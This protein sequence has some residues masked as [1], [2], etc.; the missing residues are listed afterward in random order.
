MWQDSRITCRNDV[1]APC[2]KGQVLKDE[3][4]YFFR[5]PGHCFGA[6]K[7][8]RLQTKSGCTSNSAGFGDDLV[9]EARVGDVT[10]D[11]SDDA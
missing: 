8:E 6:R 5:I 9:I 10:T 11:S 1:Y 7:P 4:E 3:D 2:P